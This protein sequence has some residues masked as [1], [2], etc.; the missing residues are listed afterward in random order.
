MNIIYQYCHLC[1]CYIVALLHCFIVSLLQGNYNISP[2][3]YANMTHQLMGLA[4]GKVVIVLEVSHYAIL[5]PIQH[6]TSSILV[7]PFSRKDSC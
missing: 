7:I 1:I 3:G 2:E 5:V 6:N 4:E